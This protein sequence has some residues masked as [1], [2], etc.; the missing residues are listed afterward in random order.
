MMTI[1]RLL[2]RYRGKPLLLSIAG[3]LFILNIGRLGIAHY[4]EQREAAETKLAL[5]AKYKTTVEQLPELRQRV[6]RLQQ[7]KQVAD[8]AF[9]SGGTEEEIAS[10]MQIM[11]QDMVV[12][13]GLEPEYI[14]SNRTGSQEAGRSFQEITIK[15]RLSGDINKFVELLSNLYQSK[16]YYRVE[17]FSIQQGKKNEL[18]IFMD[19]IGYYT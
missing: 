6:A 14:K 18:R 19:L 15:M 17:S 10:K 2:A 4:Q 5:L 16:T 3:A 13:A 12:K 8:Q 1:R 9:M 7:E 11:L